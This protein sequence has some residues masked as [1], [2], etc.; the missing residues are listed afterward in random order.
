MVLVQKLPHLLLG[1]HLPRSFP[2]VDPTECLEVW[3]VTLQDRAHIHRALTHSVQRPAESCTPDEE[4]RLNMRYFRNTSPRKQTC[5]AFPRQAPDRILCLHPGVW[6]W[7]VPAKTFPGGTEEDK[8]HAHWVS[9]HGSCGAA[10]EMVSCRWHTLPSRSAPKLLN[11]K[12]ASLTLIGWQNWP[13]QGWGCASG[14]ARPGSMDPDRRWGF[15][16]WSAA[17]KAPDG[18]VSRCPTGPRVRGRIVW[19]QQDHSYTSYRCMESLGKPGGRRLRSDLSTWDRDIIKLDLKWNIQP[20]NYFIKKKKT[21]HLEQSSI[22]SWL[23]MRYWRPFG[24]CW[25]WKPFGLGKIEITF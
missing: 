11:V 14:E 8:D 21:T 12:Q 6:L 25:T 3:A 7:G 22:A 15:Q 18:Q 10:L 4:F 17:P 24:V 23:L 20:P 16:D 2:Y 19:L 5:R 9:W 1:F 13:E